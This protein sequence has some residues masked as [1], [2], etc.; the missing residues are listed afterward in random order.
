MNGSVCSTPSLSVKAFSSILD[1]YKADV[2][3]G[4][5][6]LDGISLR[7]RC[8]AQRKQV[9]ASQSFNYS[10]LNSFLIKKVVIFVNMKCNLLSH[11]L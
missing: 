3:H 1:F 10:V 8:T 9:L 4:I 5:L 6:F 2:C 11:V 7:L